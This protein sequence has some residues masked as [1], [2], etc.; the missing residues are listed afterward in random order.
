[1]EKC[2]L[3]VEHEHTHA[4]VILTMCPEL[5]QGPIILD[6]TSMKIHAYLWKLWDRIIV[7]RS[8]RREDWKKK[9]CAC[10]LDLMEEKQDIDLMTKSIDNVIICEPLV[11]R[12][13][14]NSNKPIQEEGDLQTSLSI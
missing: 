7:A 13:I 12:Q 9:F 1:M 14:Q 5:I 6:K 10:P 2:T 11:S 8:N 4:E 3:E